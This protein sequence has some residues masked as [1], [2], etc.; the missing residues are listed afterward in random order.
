MKKHIPYS[1]FIQKIIVVIGLF[2]VFPAVTTAQNTREGIKKRIS[3]I[4]NEMQ[5]LNHKRE[6]IGLEFEAISNFSIKARPILLSYYNIEDAIKLKQDE[7]REYRLYSDERR[8][9]H[10]ELLSLIAQRDNY[11]TQ[12]KNS[13]GIISYLPNTNERC[14]SMEEL[15]LEFVD[16]I[17][18]HQKI[19]LEYDDIALQ[20]GKLN[21]E[22]VNL[23][24]ELRYA[25][26]L[27]NVSK[28]K[29]INLEGCWQL[30]T[31]KYISQINVNL[32]NQIYYNGYVMV[33]NL[34]NYSNGQHI[35][36]VEWVHGSTYRGKEIT[37]NVDNSGISRRNDIPMKITID[38]SGNFLT[39]TSTEET[40]TMQ[41]CPPN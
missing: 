19:K 34:E 21:N 13:G 30:R 5:I 41:R 22:K 35:F 39:W 37:Y 1:K 31:G 20:L 10:D 9:K 23:N 4:D 25:P 18:H 7:K 40:V 17:N 28:E 16:V 32:N 3:T 33:S 29:H 2:I 11:N 26:D 6:A 24:S 27:W 12:F 15:Q 36:T 38:S 14:T 8:K